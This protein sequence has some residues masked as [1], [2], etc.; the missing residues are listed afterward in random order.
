MQVKNIATMQVTTVTPQTTVQEIVKLMQQEDIGFVPVVEEGRAVG[1]ITDRD[2][3]L[4]CLA[5]HVSLA[6]FHAKDVMT[7]HVHSVHME[8]DLEEAAWMMV[9]DQVRRLVVLNEDREPVGV[10]TL[11]DLA[12]FGQGPETAGR[13]LRNLLRDRQP[14]VRQQ[15][16]EQVG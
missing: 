4:R 12:M 14:T 11:D 3:A 10:I 9:N 6:P 8:A 2:L 1:V 13:V 16:I 15:Q 7:R 5:D